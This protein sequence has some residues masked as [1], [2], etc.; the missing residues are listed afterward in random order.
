MSY[1][2]TASGKHFHYPHPDPDAITIEDI[3]QALSRESRF[4]GHTT[5]FY[6]VAQHSITASYL[7]APEFSLEALLHDASEAYMKDLPSPLKCLLPDY[8]LIE[9]YVD[10]AIRNK[11]GL[12]IAMSAAVKHADLVMLA[13]ER[14]D[15]MPADDALWPQL[16]GIE[17]VAGRIWPIC[18]NAAN[19]IFLDRFL[20]LTKR[21]DLRG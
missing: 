1:I 13:T 6:S 15:L 12:P 8:K 11:F 18:S 9:G 21:E 2:L 7:V 3:A 19:W 4:N 14:R 5:D 10:T 17:P 16:E 20:E